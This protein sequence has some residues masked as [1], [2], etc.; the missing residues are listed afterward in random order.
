MWCRHADIGCS[1]TTYDIVAGTDERPFTVDETTGLV[2]TSGELDREIRDQYV[3]TGT[4]PSRDTAFSSASL[5]VC[6]SVCPYVCLS[7]CQHEKR[8][9]VLQYDNSAAEVMLTFLRRFVC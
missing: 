4:L 3:I 8:T 1:N 5:Y 9:T 7:V 2:L 6:L